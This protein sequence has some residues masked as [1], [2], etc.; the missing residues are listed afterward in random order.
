MVNVDYITAEF[1]IEHFDDSVGLRGSFVLV[2]STLVLHC[3][4]RYPLE[5][6]SGISWT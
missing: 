2:P 4:L 3:Y 5:E 1:A 6:I